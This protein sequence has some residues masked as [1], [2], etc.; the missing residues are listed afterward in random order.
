MRRFFLD[1]PPVN[2]TARIRGE[3]ARHIARVLRLGVGDA[4]ELFDA[5]G[6]VYCAEIESIGRGEVVARICTRASG[7]QH[8]G[9]HIVLCQAVVKSQKMDLIVEKCTELGAAVVQPF[10]AARSVPRWDRAR[11]EQRVQHWQSVARSAVK[12]SGARRPPS[13]EPVLG[14]SAMLARP[15][16]DCARVMLWEA[17]RGA[18]LRSL[19]TQVPGRRIV[20]LVGPEGGFT[21]EEAGEARRSGFQAAGLGSRILRAETAAITAVALAAYE[22]G[23]LGG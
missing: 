10:F 23:M 8:S 2:D 15:F 9:A 21:P 19:L 6:G 20:L 18:D 12:Q 3:E 22:Y 17:E 16:T 1:S 13:I 5:D 7:T 4:L 11:A 14:F